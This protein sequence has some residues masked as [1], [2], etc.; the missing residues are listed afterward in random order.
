MIVVILIAE[1]FR[2]AGVVRERCGSLG[3]EKKKCGF[4]RPD[5]GPPKGVEPGHFDYFSDKHQPTMAM[6]LY[7]KAWIKQKK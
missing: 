2:Q 3:N 4:S 7:V 1:S 6:A 5:I